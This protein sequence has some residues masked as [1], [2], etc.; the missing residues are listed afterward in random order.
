[1]DQARDKIRWVN[2]HMQGKGRLSAAMVK[3]DAVFINNF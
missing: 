2:D 1:M 3:A